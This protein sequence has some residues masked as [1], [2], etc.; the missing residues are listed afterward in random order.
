[1]RKLFITLFVTCTLSLQAFAHTP[2]ASSVPKDKATLTIAPKGIILNFKNGIRLTKVVLTR[3]GTNGI[4]LKLDN[5]K[6]FQA[7]C[8]FVI[9]DPN[10]GDYLIEWRGLGQDGHVMK[11]QFTYK[12]E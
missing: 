8:I 7:D 6:K 10:S 1:M 5:K 12:V 9:D 11:G 4:K 3:V 2:L